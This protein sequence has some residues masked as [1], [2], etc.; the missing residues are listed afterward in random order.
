MP[1]TMSLSKYSLDEIKRGIRDPPL[2]LQEMWWLYRR[3]AHA[4]CTRWTK[5]Q[6]SEEG[7][8]FIDQDW[9]NLI[10]LDATRFDIFSN[11][12][13]PE[14]ELSPVRSTG[15]ESW[16]F[17][18]TQ[19][20]GRELHDTVYI[21]A[22]P[23]APKIPDGTFYKVIN[24]LDD[25]W[26]EEMQTVLPE[27][28]L[29]Q[30]LKV[31]QEYPQKR[32]ISHW[33]QPHFPFIG[34]TGRQLEQSG[35][36]RHLREDKQGEKMQAWGYLNRLWAPDPSDYITAYEENHEIAVEYASEAAEQLAGKSVITADHANLL[37]ERLFPLP[38]REYGHP[39]DIRIPE[40]IMVP[41]LEVENEDDERRT[42]RT[43]S[44]KATEEIATDIVS[45]RLSAMGYLDS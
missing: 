5:Y 23:H 38:V 14:G 9:D 2:I 13:L 16:E 41:W 18:R 36:V 15:S 3:V 32:L 27:V 20:V 6:Y 30:T 11:C 7:I 34:P 29:E 45:D 24:L 21:T 28:M 25:H 17:M 44:P 1:L 33:M 19:F 4:A 22:N 37:G 31:A 26:D 40:L 8:D 42:I 12:D 10:I 39:R 43:E 35:L